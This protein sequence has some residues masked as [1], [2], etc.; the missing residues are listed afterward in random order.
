M[1]NIVI[2]FA[3]RVISGKQS[4]S[5][6]PAQLKEDVKNLLIEQGFESLCVEDE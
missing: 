5:S 6:I 3:Q 2:F 4:F 1:L